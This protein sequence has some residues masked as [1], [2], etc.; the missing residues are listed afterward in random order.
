MRDA[1]E[2][3]AVEVFGKEN[4]LI[5][6][7]EELGELISAISRY[8]LNIDGAEQVMEEIADVIIMGEQCKKFIFDKEYIEKIEME[9]LMRLEKIVKYNYFKKLKER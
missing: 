3:K 7:Q 1:I 2:K 6:F 9:K 8:L 5:K 4:Q